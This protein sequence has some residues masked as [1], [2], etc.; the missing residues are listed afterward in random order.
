MASVVTEQEESS[1]EELPQDALDYFDGDELQARCFIEKY[2]LETDEGD[3]VETHPKQMWE[4]VAEAMSS[5]EDDQAEWF[6]EFYWLLEDFKFVP[7]GRILHGAGNPRDVTLTNC[8]YTGIEEDSLEAI[9]DWCK[10]AARTYSYGGGNGVDIGVLRPQGTPVNNAARTS[11]GAVSFMELFSTTTGTIGQHG[12]RGALMISSPIWHPDIEDFVS[13]KSEDLDSV[14]YANISVKVDDAFMEAVQAGEEYTLHYESEEVGRV[15]DTIDARKLWDEMI[16]SAHKSAEPGI[17]F[18]D[19]VQEQS[20]S[21]YC[22]P[23][24]GT[25]PCVTGDT[26]VWVQ[27]EGAVPIGELVGQTPSIGTVAKGG[28]EFLPAKQ[29]VQTGVRTVFRLRTEEGYELGLTEDHRVLTDKGDVPAH[30]LDPGDQIRLAVPQPPHVS[31]SSEDAALGEVVGWLTGD[32]H[33]TNHEQD[34][35]TAVLSFYGDDKKQA[36]PRLLS[37]VQDLIDDADLGLNAVDDRDMSYVRSQRLRRALADEGIDGACKRE[38]PE[39]VRRGTHDLAAGYLRGLFSADG[40]VQ[41]TLEKGFSAR[42]AS[43]E[44]GILKDAQQLLLRL[45]IKSKIYEDRRTEHTKLLPDSNRELKE[46]TCAAQHELVV[47]RSSLEAFQQTVGFI[48]EA[49]QETLDEALEA[50]DEGPYADTEYATVDEILAEG[51]EEVFDLTEPVTSHFVADGLVVHNC[52]E[53]PLESNGAC[54]LGHVNLAAFVEDEF[55]DDAEVN[56]DGVERAVRTGVRFLDD[57]VE[58]N[59]PLHAHEKQATQARNTRRIGL[60][61]TGLGDMLAKLQIKYDTDDAID[62]VDALMERIRNWAYDESSEIA[63]EKEPFPLFDAEE[64]LERPFVQRLP[65][66]LRSKIQEQGLRNVCMLTVAPVGSGSVLTGTTSG[67]EPIFQLKYQRRS[68]SLSQEFYEVE[69]RLV[70]EYRDATDNQEG[71]LPDFFVTSHDIDPFFRVKMQGTLQQYVDSAISSTVNLP[72]DIEVD[73]VKEIYEYA[74]ELG[75]K[76]VTVYR[77]SSREGILITEEERESEAE[78]EEASAEATDA[79]LA[80]TP[81]AKDDTEPTAIQEPQTTPRPRPDVV[82]GT[83]Q[84]IETGYGSLYVTINE[85]DRGLFEVF[86]QIGRGGGYTASFTEAVARLVSLGL[87]SGVPVEEIIEQLEGIRSPKIAWDHGEQVYS[88]P[89]AM[90][91]ALERQLSGEFRKSIQARVD[92]FADGPGTGT[93]DETSTPVVP[94]T[95]EGKETVDEE[96]DQ[97]QE[98]V[99]HGR[100]PEC[101]DCNAM[102]VYEEGCVKCHQCGH[103]EC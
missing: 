30:E 65:E 47:S 82:M 77:E 21:E 45:G 67:V 73:T 4:R 92:T 9:F 99:R 97:V 11:S 66:D 46:Y 34:K 25:N 61:V 60:G 72:A 1:A 90:A 68:E 22:A 51:E 94:D 49:K 5:V 53:Q 96:R 48:V 7:G 19:N 63:A 36:A 59:L 58:Y 101:P 42:L 98:M 93:Q 17:L 76:G 2:A 10:S 57:V 18:W 29:V 81:V 83:T 41:G 24:E 43:N 54:T 103:S 50:Y 52:G 56:W 26:R 8:Y 102:L 100:S 62:F 74:W 23:V 79:E 3:L 88:V 85:D 12:R 28:V 84:K 27:D 70:Q 89:D 37:A 86:A 35:P 91:T 95:E 14:R 39:P 80:E 69:H 55:Q 6:D 71:E 38:V 87:R 78:T 20:P 44:L 13:I 31:W 15:E 75:C 32:G 33:F 40:S 64:H 16:S